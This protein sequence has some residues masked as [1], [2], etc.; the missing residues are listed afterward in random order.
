V[1][2]KVLPLLLVALAIGCNKKTDPSVQSPVAKQPDLKVNKSN[3]IPKATPDF[4]SKLKPETNRESNQETKSEEK[5]AINYQWTKVVE[6]E[7]YIL[8]ELPT[9]KT[10]S[11]L[12]CTY[13]QLDAQLGI[14]IAIDV[15]VIANSRGFHYFQF[16]EYESPSIKISESLREL[17]KLQP[18]E[19]KFDG[20]FTINFLDSEAPD[21]E[22]VMDV[23]SMVFLAKQRDIEQKQNTT[24]ID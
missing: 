17:R 11:V 13:L 1:L 3:A 18:S 16:S 10:Q 7:W 24:I 5:T 14:G 20:L 23:Q 6:N 21:L 15:G 22:N 19:F 12:N 9:S 2:I 4:D 8:Y